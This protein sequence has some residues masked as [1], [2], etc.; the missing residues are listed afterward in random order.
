MNMALLPPGDLPKTP[1]APAP[2]AGHFLAPVQ[3]ALER[4]PRESAPGINFIGAMRAAWSSVRAAAG[5]VNRTHG[6]RA[7]GELLSDFTDELLGLLLR[8]AAGRAGFVGAQD[9]AIPGIALLSLGSY[10]RRELAPYS[11]IDLLVLHADD[12][13]LAGLETL[14]GHLLRP[15]W[16]AGLQVGHAVRLRRDC[17]R[18]MEDVASGDSALQT[19]TAML[20]ARFVA[21]DRAFADL[22]F[23]QDLASFF[24]RHGRAFVDAKYEETIRRWQGLSVQHTQPNLKDSPGALRDF[25]LAAWVDRASQLSG[26]LPRLK[27]RPLVSRAA[28]ED[29]RA[30]YERVLTFRVSLHTHCRRRQDVLDFAMQQ[31]VADD[32][33][34]GSTDDLKAPEM[35]LRDY[36]RA[37]T[38]VH[39]LAQTVTRR[40]VQERAIAMG[41]FE[42][43]RRHEVDEDFMR[44]GDYLYAAHEG[45]FAGAHWPEPALR[46]YLHAARL[47]IS[48]SLDVA[49][50]IGARVPEMTDAWRD[51]PAASL[52]LGALLR[53][54]DNVGL[55][56]REMRDIGLLGSYLPEFGE[57]EG[58]AISDVYHDYAVDEHTLLVVEAV[59]RLY[60]SDDPADRLRQQILERL[61][62]PV[63]LRLACLLH[64]LGKSRG[65]SRHSERGALMVPGLGERLGLS[66]ADVRTLIFLVEEHLTLSKVSQRRDLR[67]GGLLRDL[68]AKTGTRERLDLLYLLSYCDA[69]SVGRGSF[70]A[71]KDELLTELYQGILAHLPSPAGEAA[72]AAGADDSAALEAGLLAW[73]KDDN[74]R[75]LALEHCRRVPPRYLVEVSVGEAVLHLETLK[76]MRAGNREAAVAVHEPGDL[77]DVW[78]VST[79]RPRRFSQICGAFLGYG[80]SIISAIAYTRADGIILDHFRVAPGPEAT[81]RGFWSRLAAGV[82]DTLAGK[83]DFEKKIEVARR[84]IP[85]TPPIVLHIEPD[86]RVDNKLSDHFTVVDVICGDRVG[87]LY[88][89]SRAL[90]D[91]SCDI[92]FAKIATN[93]GVVSD[94]FYI[95]EIG[96]GQITDLE[97]TRNIKRLLK[98]VAADFQEAKR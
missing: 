41:E 58:L 1:P 67:E 7:A 56:L 81:E 55:A 30:G 57:I 34:Y 92:H 66:G 47:G 2:A 15:L 83:G 85:H 78:V 75:A 21:G 28:I 95:S 60:R 51:H 86:V 70:P 72:V 52:H 87:L 76:R 63:V 50:A 84:R 42:W 46:A 40:Y 88:G 44:V 43:G 4:V 38:A 29:A 90:G 69:V 19:T 65:A 97:K 89:L 54:R 8:F 53:L 45:V 23:K 25:Q 16:D 26:H 62:R 49:A 33:A 77:A 93:Q 11:D 98:A 82:E 36:F 79:D 22:F 74:D 73:A 27:D 32:L 17:V 39:R 91:L 68:A 13:P 59:D 10:A 64:D 9:T 3:E 24:Q 37:A 12:V 31:A 61:P 80:V 5:E 94:V 35:L 96:G 18:A 48:V 6:G 20:E 14:V 71:W